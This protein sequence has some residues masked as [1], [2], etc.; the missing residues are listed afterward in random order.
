MLQDQRRRLKNGC[1]ESFPP[2]HHLLNINSKQDLNLPILNSNNSGVLHL[3]VNSEAI[4]SLEVPHL[5]VN[6]EANLSS[7]VQWEV[8]F[9][10]ITMVAEETQDLDLELD[11]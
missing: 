9:M 2:F 3:V 1:L 7:E 10:E 11:F 6:L 5:G 4:L 8:S